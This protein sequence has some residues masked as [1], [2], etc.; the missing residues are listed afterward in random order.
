MSAESEREPVMTG[1]YQPSGTF[2]HTSAGAHAEKLMPVLDKY[3]VDA[4]EVE[5]RLPPKRVLNP[6]CFRPDTTPTVVEQMNLDDGLADN[7]AR[8]LRC[9]AVIQESFAEASVGSYFPLSTMFENCVLFI[10]SAKRFYDLNQGIV[11]KHFPEVETAVVN[12]FVVTANKRSYGTH[13]ASGI[14]LQIPSLVKKRLGFP[15]EYRSFHTA[16]TPTPLDRQPFVIFEE[17]EVEAPNLQFAYEKIMEYGVDKEEK[18]AVDKALYLFLEGKLSEIDLPT[19]RD[20]L[21][22]KYWEK[23]YADTPSPGYYCDSRVGDALVFDN[24]RAH[25]DGTLPGS[26]QDRLTI[27]FRCFNKVHYPAGMSSGLDFIVDP[28]ERDYQIARKRDSIDFL[29]TT[30]G[31]ED[32]DEFLYLVFGTRHTDHINP[33]GLMTDLQFGVYNK[34][35]HHLLDQNLDAH[36]ERVERLYDQ[37]E[38][39]GEYV[40]PERAKQRLQALAR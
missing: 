14:A 6:S 13:S 40:L 33:F 37:I 39:D 4:G 12:A 35:E 36:Y 20:F 34:S 19:V 38:R 8:Q 10:P 28:D 23:R 18:A 32:I 30:L 31:Y 26:P 11:H 22:A 24:Y 1:T 5:S 17:A 3:P 27:D 9:Q 2:L 21:M 16:V 25:G 7:L 29:L 15:T